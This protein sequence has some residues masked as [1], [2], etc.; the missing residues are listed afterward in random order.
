[1]GNAQGKKSQ[2]FIISWRIHFKILF[3]TFAWCHIKVSWQK[4]VI[5]KSV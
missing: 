5:T 2:D 3:T 4:Q 1:M